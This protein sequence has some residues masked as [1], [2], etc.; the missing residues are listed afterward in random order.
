VSSLRIC[1][2][3]RLIGGES[4][5]VEQALIGLAY[6]LSRLRDGEEE[7]HFLTYADADQWIRPYL[8]GNCRLLTGPP[9][10]R[11]VKEGQHGPIWSFLRFAFHHLSPL[12]G[13]RTIRVERSGGHPEGLGA[14]VMHFT[15]QNGFLTDVPSIYQ[16]WDLQHLHLPQFFTPRERLAREVWYR[17]FC[18]QAEVV[19][20]PSRWG[21][22]DIVQRYG[23]PESKVAVVP[24]APATASYPEPSEA[25]LAATRRRHLLPERFILYPAQ[26]WPHKN[27]LGLLDALAHLRD[28]RGLRV[29]LVCT[30]RR[31]A[32]FRRIQ[33][34]VRALN[35]ADQVQFLGFVGPLELRCLYRL[36]R[37]VVFPT[38]FEGLGMPVLEAF[39]AGVPVACS[40]VTCLPE[41]VGDAALLFNP[42]RR[43]E[44][45][46]A[47]ERLWTEGSLCQELM[48]RGYLRVGSFSWDRTALVFRALYRK[49]AG[50]AL[51]GQDRELLHACL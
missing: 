46:W 37:A 34:R 9:V 17:M 42:D 41:L 47:V 33:R 11:R 50:R 10:P 44:M 6:G 36:C 43:E 24:G 19:V 7:Y 14:R 16:P 1:L 28:C 49:V 26:T 18:D 39:L 30:G 20:A 4:G 48:E 40:Q 12:L 27:H 8:G 25:D 35:L 23:V 5:G 15:T 22:R 21:K 2:D 51:T 45:A 32:F 3:A 29:P 13:R 31:N 38:L